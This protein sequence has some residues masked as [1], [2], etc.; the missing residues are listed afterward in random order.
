M[1]KGKWQYWLGAVGLIAAAGVLRA[2]WAYDTADVELASETPEEY[3]A[4]DRTPARHARGALL[5]VQEEAAL[6]LA[7]DRAPVWGR[8]G[9]LTP[10]DLTNTFAVYM[11][12]GDIYGFNV[13]DA[14]GFVDRY[15]C[16]LFV[17]ELLYRAGLRIPI[18]ARQRG[19][20][21]A[22]PDE[23]LRQLQRGSFDGGWALLADHYDIDAL[24]RA[25][26]QGIPFM[27]VAQGLEGRAGHMGVVDEIHR[28][29]HDG[30]GRILRVEYSGW[31]ANGDGAHYRRRT[32]TVHRF[33]EIHML[34]LQEPE[35]EQVQ[36]YAISHP[37]QRSDLDA[38]R[39]ARRRAG[40]S[41]PPSVSASP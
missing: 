25:N 27:L 32:W 29:R 24:R 18:V 30:I 23:V 9:R 4:H 16:N 26:A 10:R 38:P 17:F 31:E 41:T 13:L 14:E 7:P 35:P 15:K 39:F 1:K 19:W 36:C 21:Y 37:G 8:R 3:Y 22:G 2:A 20:G 5:R 40:G 28:I 11:P 34:E 12:D 6:M 33:A